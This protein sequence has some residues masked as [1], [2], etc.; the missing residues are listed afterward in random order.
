MS[1]P[2]ASQALK[3]LKAVQHEL[4][5]P[6][7]QIQTLSETARKLPSFGQRLDEIG[8][9]P[10]RPTEIEILQINVG[11]MC[12]LTCAPEKHWVSSFR[13]TPSTLERLEREIMETALGHAEGG[14]GDPK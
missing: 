11:K 6:L 5:D 9:Y 2:N 1:S 8:L 12:N 7:V 10:L 3:S 4:S 14:R 13:V